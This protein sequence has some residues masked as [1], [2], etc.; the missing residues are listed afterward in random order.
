[1]SGDEYVNNMLQRLSHWVDG[2]EKEFLEWGI[3]PLRKLDKGHASV[4]I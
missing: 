4:D 1:M 3:M 2:A